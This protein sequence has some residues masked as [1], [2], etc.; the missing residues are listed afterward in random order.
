MNNQTPRELGRLEAQEQWR[1]AVH[2]SG[3]LVISRHIGRRPNRF[4][5]QMIAVAGLV[6]ECCWDDHDAE[7]G[8]VVGLLG[9]PYAMSSEDWRMFDCTPGTFDATGE[10][11]VDAVFRVLTLELGVLSPHFRAAANLLLRNCANV[12]VFE[13]PRGA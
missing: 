2:T 7:P 8:E 9:N 10:A 3:H 5:R 11:A 1:P 13:F 12:V 4:E 6:A